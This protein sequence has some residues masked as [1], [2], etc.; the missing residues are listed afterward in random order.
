MR[1]RTERHP[2]RAGD[3]LLF[4]VVAA[5]LVAPALFAMA[6]FTLAGPATRAALAGDDPSELDL[7]AESTLA[8]AAR[9]R[10]GDEAHGGPGNVESGSTLEPEGPAPIFEPRVSRF[11]LSDTDPSEAD[12]GA[13]G[14]DHDA[15]D[16]DPVDDVQTAEWR[17]LAV[18]APGADSHARGT[19]R[20]STVSTP[21]P[22]AWPAG[23]ARASADLPILMY[24]YT[25]PLPPNPDVFRRDLTVSPALFEGQLTSLA[26]SGI[27]TVTLDRLFDHL[28]G[29]RPL[30]PRAVALTFDDGYVDNYEVAFPLLKRY[31][32][33]GTFFVTTGF[34]GRPGYMTW[35]QLEEMASAGMAIEAHS[36]THADLTKI[37]PAQLSRELGVPKQQLEERLGRPCRFLAYPGGRFDPAVIRATKAAGYTAAV[38]TQHGLRH[39]GAGPFELTRVRVRGT[40]TVQQLVAKL[41]P[42]TWRTLARQP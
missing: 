16:H 23:P 35:E 31:G 22:T 18:R 8:P 6:L 2:P 5:L 39:T 19:H 4:V 10:S 40:E 1:E 7:P 25:G 17:P 33:V 14:H 24:H 13:G 30:P 12:P 26:D 37:A 27:E 42:P 28:E 38:T 36:V 41:T 3:G 29:R 15:H 32:M 20:S 34:V 21:A 9:E 11:R